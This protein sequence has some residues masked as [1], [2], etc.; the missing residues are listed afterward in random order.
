MHFFEGSS[1]SECVTIEV[2]GIESLTHVVHGNDDEMNADG[3]VEEKGEKGADDVDGDAGAE[4]MSGPMPIEPCWSGWECQGRMCDDDDWYF[5]SSYNWDHQ[6]DYPHTNQEGACYAYLA[7]TDILRTYNDA[8]DWHDANSWLEACQDELLSLRETCT[9]TSV[10]IDEV[11]SWNVVR[12][13][14]VFAIKTSADGL[15][16]CYKARIVAKGFSQVYQVNYDETF[17]PVVKWDSICILLTLAAQYNLEVHQMDVKTV[18]LN[19]DLDHAI[20]MEPPPGSA[21]YGSK[22]VV[23]KLKKSLYG[24]LNDI[25]LL[26][27]KK[28]KL[29]DTFKMKDLGP[30]HWFLGLKI[31]WDQMWHSISISQSRYVL[32]IVECFGFTNSCPISTPIATSFQLPHLNVPEVNDHN[33]QSQIGSIMY[34]MLG[35]HPNIA[36]VVGALSQYL[37]NHGPDHL[38]AVNCVLKYLNSTKDYKLIYNGES[39]ESDFIAYC[40]SDWA[41]DPCDH[42]LTSSYVFKIAGAAV[43]WSSKKQSSTTLSSTKGKYMALTHAAKEALWIQ[44]FLYNV[45]YPPIF[46]TTILGNNQGALVLAVNPA[47]HMHMKHICVCQHFIRECVNEGSIELEYVLFQSMP[48]ERACWNSML[49]NG[50]W[51]S[52]DLR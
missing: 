22:G 47:F 43:S 36:Y 20:Y 23:W 17:A 32:D 30:I 35:T 11:G 4:E 18:F 9:Y 49:I 26:D 28:D 42:W 6:S 14:W 50:E 52:M 38:T 7:H 34:M 10:N 19:S 41:G 21:N 37:A 15:I 40:D 16:K 2:P 3:E 46:P 44:E 39:K 12:C 1:D 31:T 33:Y 8:M 27:Q 5:V 45:N 25:N 51:V 24:L 13:H 48:I 29:K